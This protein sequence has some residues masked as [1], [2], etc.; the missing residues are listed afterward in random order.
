MM[1]ETQ[2]IKTKQADKLMLE[3]PGEEQVMFASE[4]L[5]LRLRI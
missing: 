5:K 3:E 4:I 1:V 2:Q